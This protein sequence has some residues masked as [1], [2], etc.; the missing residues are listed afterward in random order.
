M[1]I[2]NNNTNSFGQVTISAS[3]VENIGKMLHQKAVAGESVFVKNFQDSL[4]KCRDTK[5]VDLFVTE[6]GKVFVQDKLSGNKKYIKSF[7]SLLSN[8]YS[9][10]KHVIF[11]EENK[12][13]F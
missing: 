5:F 3:T 8:M 1:Q 12:F 7:S 9:G 2:T 10:I 11:A 13:H 4:E 6:D